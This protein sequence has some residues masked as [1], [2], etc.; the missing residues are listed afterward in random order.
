MR[1]ALLQG[2]LVSFETVVSEPKARGPVTALDE[3][4]AL[5]DRTFNLTSVPGVV[6][7]NDAEPE[8]GVDHVDL[9]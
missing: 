8:V 5:R 3:D 4:A 2:P 1:Q 7:E 9:F 6:E